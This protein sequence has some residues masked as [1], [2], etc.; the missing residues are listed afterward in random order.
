M[1][2]AKNVGTH[3]INVAQNLSSKYGQKLLDSAKKSATD[4]IKTASK[5]AIQKTAETTSDLIDNKIADKIRNEA[6]DESEAPK[7]RYIFP[8]ETTNYW[9]IKASIII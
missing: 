8:E 1:S 5:W 9:W 2:F 7:E 6:N 4:A 3:A